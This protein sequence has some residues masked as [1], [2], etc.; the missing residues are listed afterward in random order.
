MSLKKNPSRWSHSEEVEGGVRQ[1]PRLESSGKRNSG[2]RLADPSYV[3]D[4][5]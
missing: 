1:E 3:P 5:A 2:G 4:P